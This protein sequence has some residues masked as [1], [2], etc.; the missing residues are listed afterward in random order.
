MNVGFAAL[1]GFEGDQGVVVPNGESTEYVVAEAVRRFEYGDLL[2]AR[3]R[4]D[5]VRA[6][7]ADAIGGGGAFRFKVGLE[8][9]AL[10][11]PR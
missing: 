5:R 3:D 7:R 9:R 4:P 6:D 1:G 10:V 11:L 2:S 8:V